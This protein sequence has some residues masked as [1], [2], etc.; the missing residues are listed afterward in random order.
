MWHRMRRIA[1][2]TAV[3]WRALLAALVGLPLIGL[4]LR[5]HGVGL[6]RE[7]C[8]A[9]PTGSAPLPPAA[10]LPVA[11]QMARGVAIA[12]RHGPYR[13]SCLER[14]LVLCRL[15][16]R[17]G[18]MCELRFGADLAQGDLAAHAWVEWEGV[19]LNDAPQIGG[20]FSPFGPGS[21]PGQSPE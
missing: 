11:H 17:R 8:L 10:A 9:T 18:V 15:L 6:V 14:S 2:L 5:I 13:A 12:A 1:A 20:R 21:T 16:R 7:R 3:E 19:V 4:S